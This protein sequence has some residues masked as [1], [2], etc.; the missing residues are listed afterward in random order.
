MLQLIK[1]VASDPDFP[2]S[3]NQLGP[4]AMMFFSCH[5]LSK[6]VYA[7][8]A[9]L[10][11]KIAAELEIKKKRWALRWVTDF[12][13]FEWDASEKRLGS[14][15]HPFTQPAPQDVEEIIS[16][17]VS[18][19]GPEH[20]KRW[21]SSGYDLVLNGREIGGGSA[22]IFHGAL[23]E[24]IFEILGIGAR[25]REENFGFFLEALKMGAPPHCGM[26]LGIDRIISLLRHKD[27]I[28]DVI[29]FPKT[30]QGQC[31]MSSAP[32][33]LTKAQLKELGL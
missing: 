15:H 28:R 8:L 4:G 10:R 2:L 23:Q 26:A 25:Q 13:L 3:Q 5:S 18:E 32:G 27:S 6:V 14:C 33:Q 24:R 11:Q 20:A 17:K 19:M 12:P 22:R 1:I 31:L 21:K 9:E 29:A 16:L 7:T 30:G